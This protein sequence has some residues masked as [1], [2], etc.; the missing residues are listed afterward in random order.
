MNLECFLH[1]LFVW[2]GWQT[3]TSPSLQPLHLGALNKIQNFNKKKSSSSQ[4]ALSQATWLTLI[5]LRVYSLNVCTMPC[6]V[7]WQSVLTKFGIVYKSL[8]VQDREPIE[9]D[10]WEFGKSVQSN[11]CVTGSPNIHLAV[12]EQTGKL[13]Q[14]IVT[15]RAQHPGLIE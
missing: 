14:L 13:S 8:R 2:C 11:W 6:K 5:N 7:F 1:A 12:F 10:I 4:P 15:R 3:Q 9:P